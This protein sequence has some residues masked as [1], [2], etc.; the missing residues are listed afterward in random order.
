MWQ[1]PLTRTEREETRRRI[2][3]IGRWLREGE[4][5]ASVDADL[6]GHQMR[7]LLV[8]LW[9]ASSR[10]QRTQ[11]QRLLHAVEICWFE[12]YKERHRRR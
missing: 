1:R 12:L 7:S 10:A 3:S 4:P 6:L 9:T 2:E 5:P 11:T 8:A